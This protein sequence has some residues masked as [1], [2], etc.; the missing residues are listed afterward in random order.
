ML[1]TIGLSD[2][3]VAKDPAEAEQ[4]IIRTHFDFVIADCGLSAFDTLGIIEG[5]R[6]GEKQPL[7]ATPVLLLSSD[8]SAALVS[9]AR[10][11]G[12][13]AIVAKPIDAEAFARRVA[14]VL[15]LTR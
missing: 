13:Q 10:N 4:K 6:V 8:P 15:T 5:Q 12:V 1:L 11:A 14:R 3:A 7:A 2:V 9:R